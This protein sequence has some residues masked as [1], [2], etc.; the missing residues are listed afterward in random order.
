MISILQSQAKKNA[1][2]V[3]LTMKD[4]PK[5]SIKGHA[6]EKASDK[7]FSTAKHFLCQFELMLNSANADVEHTWEHWLTCAIDYDQKACGLN[8]LKMKMHPTETVQDFGL[9]FQKACTDDYKTAQVCLSVLPQRIRDAILNN[10]YS[11]NAQNK[12]TDIATAVP[13]TA[14]HVL[15]MATRVQILP[16]NLQA[17]RAENATSFNKRPN[18]DSDHGRRSRQKTRC[19]LHPNGSRSTSECEVLKRAQ[20]NSQQPRPCR[21]C[22]APFIRPHKCGSNSDLVV[23]TVQRQDQID[24]YESLNVTL[25]EHIFLTSV[26][27]KSILEKRFGPVTNSTKQIEGWTNSCN[28]WGKR[29][30]M[31]SNGKKLEGR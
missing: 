14:E 20:G 30:A 19:L 27:Q 8:L 13:K 25:F 15:N 12:E 5:L 10:F 23:Q 6:S 28:A 26:Q 29:T 18:D 3:K 1:P 4:I 9:R 11:W 24:E 2:E 22:K 17:M 7:P 16:S 21:Y 31:K